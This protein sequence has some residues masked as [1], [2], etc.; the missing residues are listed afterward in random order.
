MKLRFTATAGKPAVAKAL[1]PIAGYAELPELKQ[2]WLEGFLPIGDRLIPR[3]SSRLGWADRL[4]ALR[5]RLGFGR[6][7]YRVLPGLYASGSPS[8]DSH[9][10]VTA[11]YKLTLDSVR[12]ELAGIDAWI[13][14]LDTKGVNVWCAA[15]KGSFGTEGLL[16][17]IARTRLADVVSHNVLILPQLGAT[18]VSA[19]EVA[20]RGRFRVSWGP[21]LAADIPAYLASGGV[22]TEAMRHVPFGLRERMA[23]APVEFTQAWPFLAG[24]LA[25]AFLAALPFGPGYAAR[26]AGIAAALAGSVL[27]G[28][29]AFPALLPHLPW[30]AFAAKGAVLGGLWGICAAALGALAGG[31]TSPALAAASVLCSAAIV[32]FIGMGFTG[33]STYTSQAGAALE[34]ERGLPWMLG[35]LALGLCLGAAARVFGL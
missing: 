13:L 3:I 22:K 35:S 10:L 30:R 1:P 20:R 23:V 15:G 12:R 7:S 16:S 2:S 19:P 21:V 31:G 4:G 11:N 24:G 29:F 34:V 32:S 26:A 14:V 5:M 27:V 28:S 18:G 6:D 17:M 9:V 25:L 8:P 33:S